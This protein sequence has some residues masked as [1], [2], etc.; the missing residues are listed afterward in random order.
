MKSVVVLQARTNS[1]RLPGKVLLPIKDI[2]LV[3][4]AS[5]R[6]ANTGREVVVAT[7]QEVTDDA[8]AELVTR[9][10]FRCFRG[11]LDNTLERVVTALEGYDDDTLVF[12]LTAD[13]VFPDGL[14]LDEIEADFIQR[15]LEYLCCNGEKSGLPYG[16][17]AELTRLRHLR[18]ANVST[19]CKHDQEHVTPYIRRMF[20]DVYFE[21]YKNLDQGHYRSTVDCF[22]DYSA[23]QKV[24]SNVD[25]PINESI[26]DLIKYL[27]TTIYQPSQAKPAT[28]L[29]LG[30]AQLGL[31][32][33]ISNLNG[34]PDQN[35][36]EGIIKTAIAEGVS[37]IDTARAYGD[38]ESVIGRAL[39]NGWSGRARI[40]TKLSPLT[41][42]PLNATPEVAAAFV[43]A[44]VYQSCTSLCIQTIDVLMLH[45][46]SHITDWHSGVW[47]RL[48]EHKSNGTIKGLGA[49]VQSPD[50][51]EAILDVP[52][53]EFVQMPFN[54]L[55]WRWEYLENKIRSRKESGNLSIHVRSS[56]LQGLLPSENNKHWLTAN[57]TQPAQ[58]IDWLAQQCH[59]TKSASVVELCLR[60]ANS[61]EWIDGVVIG[62]ESLSQLAE[63]VKIL[64]KS[65]LTEQELS[66]ILASRPKLEENTLNPA[67][68]K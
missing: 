61:I 44:S 18:K 52:Q 43:D 53:I 13:N 19:R 36:S 56:L 40:I 32:Y 37:Y 41:D 59:I 46:A 67:L 55:D 22:D 14:L 28:K 54:L 57:V 47:N 35:S 11:S 21:K 63:N 33:G 50:E 7:S 16:V 38:S 31:N 24:F 48:L 1:S 3:V 26:F 8:L 51:L 66:C 23:I 45:R 5:K 15:N 68:W 39:K 64:C 42:C 29:V 17:S 4:L 12:R 6:A 58:V 27:S 2:P 62:M 65:A 9:N 30:T 60:F 25:D 10:G 49:S 34:K 20:G